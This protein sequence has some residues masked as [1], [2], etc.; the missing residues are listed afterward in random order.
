MIEKGYEYA[1][2]V[3]NYLNNLKGYIEGYEIINLMWCIFGVSEEELNTE[4]ITNE[5]MLKLSGDIATDSTDFYEDLYL[6][7]K[8]IRK[9]EE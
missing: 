8:K 2:I 7:Y 1:N 4:L 3:C 9:V 6:L 5:D